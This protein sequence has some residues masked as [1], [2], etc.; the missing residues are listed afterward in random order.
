MRMRSRHRIDGKGG[1]SKQSG[2]NQNHGDVAVAEA[3][4]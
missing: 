2:Q 1:E 3:G 4:G